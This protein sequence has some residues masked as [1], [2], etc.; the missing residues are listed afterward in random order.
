MHKVEV[1]H[2]QRLIFEDVKR[3]R[4][5]EPES[6]LVS[7]ELKDLKGSREVVA[8]YGKGFDDLSEFFE[9]LAA[10]WSGWQGIKSYESLEG[11]LLLEAEHTGSHVELSFALQNPSFPETWYVRGRLTLDPGEELTQVSNALDQLFSR[12]EPS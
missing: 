5:G 12:R 10:Q 6:M 1:G 7:V 4:D 2:S 9:N 3:S 8:L 11:D